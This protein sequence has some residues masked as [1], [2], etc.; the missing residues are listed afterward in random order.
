MAIIDT[1]GVSGN[2]FSNPN[3]V[4]TL[5]QS[6]GGVT[7]TAAQNYFPLLTDVTSN[8]L[9]KSQ[10]Q[11]LLQSLQPSEQR[12]TSGLQDLFRSAGM[13]NSGAFAQQAANLQRDILNNRTQ[14][15]GKLA[16]DTFGQLVQALQGPLNQSSALIN[17]LKLSQA[18]Q[19]VSY[20]DQLGSTGPGGFASTF[21]TANDPYWLAA[22]GGG[23]GGGGGF[24]PSSSGG[25]RASGSGGGAQSPGGSSYAAPYEVGYSGGVSYRSDGSQVIV[26]PIAYAQAWGRPSSTSTPSN[27]NINPQTGTPYYQG[28]ANMNVDVNGRDL[29]GT[30]LATVGGQPYYNPVQ[31]YYGWNSDQNAPIDRWGYTAQ[32]WQNDP[33]YNG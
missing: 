15:A 14:A 12:A 26:D 22:T 32:D 17:S 5:A 11:G 28:T 1:T 19:P 4:N 30:G 18:Q 9:Y 24:L 16:G 21:S 13:T 27:P 10:L 29:G 20:N 33:Y 31:Q 8:P 3:L 23:G 7:G 25:G 2:Y 6:L